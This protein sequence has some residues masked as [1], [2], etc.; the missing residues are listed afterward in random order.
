MEI[1]D[2]NTVLK[3]LGGPEGPGPAQAAGI[4]IGDCIKHVQGNSVHD[5]NALI[6][7]LKMFPTGAV[8]FTVS[9]A[10]PTS[11]SPESASTENGTAAGGVAS[12]SDL[13]DIGVS[14]DFQTD[15]FDLEGDGS[16]K[17]EL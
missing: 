15:D 12:Q 11:T 13:Y 2:T 14:G 17:L 7:A 10:S 1:S 5:K 9:G 4:A 3:Y 16:G 8:V 6:D